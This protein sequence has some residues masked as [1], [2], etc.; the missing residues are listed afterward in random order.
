VEGTSELLTADTSGVFKLWDLRNFQCVQTFTTDHEP[1]DLD[2]LSG[3]LSCFSHAKFH[4]P[5]ASLGVAGERIDDYRI[6]AASKKILFFD[7]ERV[8]QDPVTDGPIRVAC[9]NTQS[10]TIFT[11]SER[12]VKIWDAVLGSLKQCYNHITNSDITA[13]C[14]DDRQRK[15]ILGLSN[16]CVTVFNYQNGAVMKHFT[17]Q[18]DTPV[19]KLIY[20]THTKSVI[21]GY[22]DG[23]IRVYDENDIE[24][25]KIV[26]SF[27]EAYIHRGDLSAVAYLGPAS[28]VASGGNLPSDGIRLWDFDSG[29]C[30]T[31]IRT[32]GFEILSLV[33]LENYPLLAASTSD[34][35]IRI[36]GIPPF[37]P[38][39]ILL[40]EFANE[41][42]DGTLLSAN[43]EAV[44]PVFN[45]TESI[46][47]AQVNWDAA[48]VTRFEWANE[49]L[50]LSKTDAFIENERKFTAAKKSRSPVS[51]MAW[52]G[53]DEC[54]YSGDEAGHLRKWDLH[55]MLKH[56]G[57]LKLQ[58][59]EATAM[60]SL[61]AKGGRGIQVLNTAKFD[62]DV[63]RRV[64]SALIEF[65][66]GKEL[67]HEADITT[68]VVTPEPRAVLTTSTDCCVKMFQTGGTKIGR[69]VQSVKSGH[70]SSCWD[71]PIDVVAREQAEAEDVERIMVEAAQSE[72]ENESVSR[73]KHRKVDT[74][75][76]KKRNKGK[77]DAQGLMTDVAV[78]EKVRLNDGSSSTL[79][80]HI[81][82][83]DH[84]SFF[85]KMHKRVLGVLANVKTHA[86][87]GKE[88]L[89]PLPFHLSII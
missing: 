29:K 53:V 58:M 27:D 21:A 3:T 43:N 77:G 62:S 6:I 14:L 51:S 73:N 47:E 50:K 25:C 57:L 80:L 36:Y 24:C 86:L 39:G 38:G 31:I 55:R 33:F 45:P 4:N 85:Y 68:V 22:M 44:M 34:S 13:A 37:V 81:N 11:A 70:Q 78:R 87:Q 74:R 2:D 1:G 48:E 63:A 7:Q 71:L 66:W 52:D 46:A 20:S 76:K 75:G 18:G 59:S 10:L 49:Y 67:A 12:N 26:R 35:M 16:G 69:L 40:A 42:P 28:L 41:L 19:V 15:F 60:R 8:R 17:P 23:L 72:R 56:L 32:E 83:H 65:R 61:R 64:T 79:I 89:V 30:E 82:S 54:L 9:F 88:D 5:I 84:V